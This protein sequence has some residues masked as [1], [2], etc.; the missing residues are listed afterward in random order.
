MSKHLDT[1]LDLTSLIRHE[2]AGKSFYHAVRHQ[3]I[4][5]L[6]ISLLITC[7]NTNVQLTI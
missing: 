3:A 4:W 1:S 2:H 5:N 7:Y 6:V